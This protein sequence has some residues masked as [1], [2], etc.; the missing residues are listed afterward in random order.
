MITK[1][2]NSPYQYNQASTG[3]RANLQISTRALNIFIQACFYIFLFSL[4]F[5]AVLTSSGFFSN[6]SSQGFWSLSRITGLMLVC[7]IITLHRP[8]FVKRLPSVWGFSVYAVL[9][10]ISAI[11]FSIAYDLSF[12][13]RMFMIPWLIMIFI[14]CCEIF[15]DPL[16][17]NRGMKVLMIAIGICAVLQLTD[18]AYN[19]SLRMS[20][21]STEMRTAAFGDD[22]NL[23]GAQYLVGLFLA[24]FISL[25]IIPGGKIIK[26]IAITVAVFCIVALI[27]SGSRGAVVSGI[28]AFLAFFLTRKPI[29]KRLAIW[30]TGIFMVWMII[31]L[32]MNDAGFR[33]RFESTFNYGDTANRN[34]IYQAS[35]DLFLASPLIGYGPDRNRIILGAVLGLDQA[36]THNILFWVL[37]ANGLIGFIPFVFGL[38]ACFYNAFRARNGPDDIAPLVLCTLAIAFSQTVSWQSEK[39]FWVLLAFAASAVVGKVS[40]NNYSIRTNSPRVG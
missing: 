26:I 33:Q 37:T 23:I 9:L 20:Y 24:I 36:D 6:I 15:H 21:V 27:Q 3:P 14:V 13:F 16:T 30:I 10:V 12:S 35:Y 17:R 25:N 8:M 31:S 38:G 19:K 34:I 11:G 5:E 4:P 40:K 1:K 7:S 18:N 32:I 39:L 28:I 22:P 29:K 2:M